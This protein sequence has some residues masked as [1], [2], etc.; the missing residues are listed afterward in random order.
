MLE[1]LKVGGFKLAKREEGLDKDH[2]LLVFRT[3]ARYHAA[4]AVQYKKD[5]EFFK[6]F[7]KNAYRE[8]FRN[9][10]LEAFFGNNIRHLANVMENWPEFDKRFSQ[11]MKKISKIAAKYFFL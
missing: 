7:F 9:S 10:I 5:P 8:H 4:S 1:D 6:I 3:L 11:Q 2:C